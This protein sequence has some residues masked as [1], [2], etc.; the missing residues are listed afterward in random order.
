M[1]SYIF[2]VAVISALSTYISTAVLLKK[3]KNGEDE[4]TA[5]ALGSISFAVLIGCIVMGILHGI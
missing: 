2:Y 3:I 4:F 5:T 1:A